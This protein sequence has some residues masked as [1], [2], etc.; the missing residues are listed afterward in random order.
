M[1]ID[2]NDVVAKFGRELTLTKDCRT[3]WPSFI[4]MLQRYIGIEDVVNKVLDNLELQKFML[5]KQK[6]SLVRDIIAA[7]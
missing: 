1:K 5:T 3:R 4:S 2:Q 6:T 7:V